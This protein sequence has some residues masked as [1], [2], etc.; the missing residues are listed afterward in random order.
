MTFIV[1]VVVVV[2]LVVW[3]Q[4]FFFSSEFID[5][6]FCACAEIARKAPPAAA[7][8]GGRK[9]RKKNIRRLIGHAFVVRHDGGPAET[10]LSGC[11]RIA[12][13][14]PDPCF[15]NVRARCLCRKKKEGGSTGHRE[16]NI[17]IF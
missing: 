11:G 2:D 7:A 9:R 1:V 12:L 5:G 3:R 8:K 14:R 15:S 13:H 17:Y 6:P 10:I 16:Y 4:G